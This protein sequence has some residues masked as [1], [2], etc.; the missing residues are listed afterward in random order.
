MAARAAAPEKFLCHGD[1]ALVMKHHHLDEIS[2][3][4]R[5]L[6]VRATSPI[7]DFRDDVCGLLPRSS[8]TRLSDL[9][10][11]TSWLTGQSVEIETGNVPGQ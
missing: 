5:D 4:G 9:L 1:S 6:T 11:P 8:R 10:P 7:R 3:D 2:I